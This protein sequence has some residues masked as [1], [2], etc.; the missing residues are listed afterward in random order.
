MNPAAGRNENEQRFVSDDGC[1][2]RLD[3]RNALIERK[4]FLP[5]RAAKCERLRRVFRVGKRCFS[6]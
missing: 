6:L 5:L 1:R 2:R 3:K 4:R